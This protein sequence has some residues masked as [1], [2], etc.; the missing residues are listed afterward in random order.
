MILADSEKIAPLYYLQQAEGLRRDLEIRVEPDEA[1][2]RYQLETAIAR[3]QTVYLARFLPGLEGIYHLRSVGPLTEVSQEPLIELPPDISPS[4]LTVNGIDL[5]GHVVERTGERNAAATLYWRTSTP[6]NQLL[7]VYT[8]WA[9]GSYTGSPIPATG[10]HPA[11]NYYPTLAWDPGEIVADFHDLPLPL[12]SQ[13]Q[14]LELQ[15]TLSPPFSDPAALE[16]HTIASLFVTPPNPLPQANPLRLSLGDNWLTGV[17]MAERTRP[18]TDL[19]IFL[20]GSSQGD[21]AILFTLQGDAAA[22]TAITSGP[23]WQPQFSTNL[24]P[25]TYQ[26]LAQPNCGDL[27]ECERVRCGWMMRPRVSC[28]IGQVEV[29]GVPLPEGATNYNDLIALLDVD[30]PTTTLQPGGQLT[31]NLQWQALAPIPDNY[32]LFL[33]VLDASDQIAG[34]V[35]S[36][37][38]QGTFPTGQWPPGAL[39]NDSYTIPLKPDLTP[40]PYR[41][42]IGWY[43]LATLQRLPLLNPDG[44]PTADSLTLP[45]LVVQE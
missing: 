17:V 1:A 37:P 14:T 41:L 42:I 45:G 35:D 4:Q 43:L 34:Q 30:L 33:Q 25:G 15:V 9:N 22:T 39:V 8:R 6:I 18:Q 44:L 26:L 3:G 19:P 38:V 40:G 24:P 32:T 29:S 31:V 10:Q 16:W 11:N 7:Y 36:W 5:L 20:S 2:Y 13:P 28:Q 21:P 12:L 23:L 27:G